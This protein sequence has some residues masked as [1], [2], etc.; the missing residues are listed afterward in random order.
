MKISIEF[1]AEQKAEI[2]A[3]LMAEFIE[4]GV[5]LQAPE[6]S[7]PYSIKEAA[8]ALNM[9]ASRIRKM[10]GVGRCLIPVAEVQRM[11]AGK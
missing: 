9:G 11:Q 4:R 2:V 5:A 10:P 3:G 8:D 7:K 6:R 1:T